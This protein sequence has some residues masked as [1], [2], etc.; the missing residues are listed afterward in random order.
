MK[1]EREQFILLLDKDKENLEAKEE[2]EKR[3]I[4]EIN[5]KTLE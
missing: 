5:N 1:I 3:K 2:E 4:E